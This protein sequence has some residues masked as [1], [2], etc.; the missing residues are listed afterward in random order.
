MASLPSRDSPELHLVLATAE[1]QVAQLHA[2]SEEWQGALSLSDYF[3]REEH[4]MAQALTKDGGLTS[5]VLVHQPAGTSENDRKVLCGC[6]SIKKRAFFAAGG[7]VEDVVAHGVASVFCP[8]QYRGQGYAG[9]MMTELGEQLKRWQMERE[10]N[11]LSILYSDIGKDFYAA[12]GWQPFPSSHISL[13]AKATSHPE[14]PHLHYLKASDVHQM[15]KSDEQQLRDSLAKRPQTSKVAVALVPD[16]ATLAWHHAREEFIAKEL[17]G[18]DADIK[19]AQIG[20]VPGERAWCFWTRVWTNPNDD[21]GN[22][23]HILRLVVEDGLT[24]GVQDFGPATE[25]GVSKVQ[26]SR[27]V[28][29]VAGLFAAAQNEAAKWD[30]EVVE[31]WNPNSVALA[32]ARKIDDGAMVHEREKASICSLRWYGDTSEKD[33]EWVCNEKYGWC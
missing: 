5:W 17:F 6:E 4:L 20:T 27:A 8:P 15:C 29:A 31:L 16:E 32:A 1:E 2:N 7:K 12:R 28:G 14:F 30:M 19:G 25:S 10:P 21:D 9:R 24:D 22:T 3:R 18:R 11:L 26:S 13:N 23:L 33:L